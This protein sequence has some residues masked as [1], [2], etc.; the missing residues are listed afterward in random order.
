MSDLAARLHVVP[1]SA[2]D[3]VETLLDRGLLKRGPD[4]DDRR[5]VLVALTAGGRRLVEQSDR[6]RVATVEE[7]VLRLGARDRAELHRLLAELQPT[8]PGGSGTEEGDA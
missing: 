6:A 1:R 5:A 2:T 3:A 7:M 4:P 8:P